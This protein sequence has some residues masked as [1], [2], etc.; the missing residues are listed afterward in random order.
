MVVFVSLEASRPN[1]TSYR[2]SMGCLVHPKVVS[3][4]AV[5]MRLF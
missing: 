5:F 3:M 1:G 2:L 4:V